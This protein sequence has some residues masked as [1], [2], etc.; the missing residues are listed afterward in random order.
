MRAGKIFIEDLRELGLL[1]EVCHARLFESLNL[2]LHVGPNPENHT[3]SIHVAALA[4]SHSKI[5]LGMDL[6]Q[7][8]VRKLGCC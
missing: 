6:L 4:C 7:Q 2:L 3:V 8:R 5:L 1:E